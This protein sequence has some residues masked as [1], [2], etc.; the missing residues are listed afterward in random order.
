MRILLNSEL[1]RISGG[2]TATSEFTC[3]AAAAAYAISDLSAGTIVLAA[4]ACTDATVNIINDVF[5]TPPPPPP[6]SIPPQ[7]NPDLASIDSSSESYS[8][9]ATNDS[10][11]IGYDSSP[12]ESY[13]EWGSY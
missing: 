6:P 1:R 11:D 8:D 10:S 7:D 9:V 5:S 2:N 12:S 4:A 3:V 13:S